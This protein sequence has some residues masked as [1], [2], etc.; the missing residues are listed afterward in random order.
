M[1]LDTNALLWVYADSSHLGA[2]AREHITQAGTAFFSG[3]SIAEIQIKHMLGK[4]SLPG[5]E[6][7]PDVFPRS[8][9]EELPLGS[10]H[11]A[12]MRHFPDLARHD[13]F[14]RMILAQAQ[15]ENLDLLTSDRTLLSLGLPWV[16]DARV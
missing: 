2:Q 12:A 5:G 3:V 13:P 7:F 14:D 1:L 4:L 15:A 8:G 10:A 16:R 9:L 6:H 11:I